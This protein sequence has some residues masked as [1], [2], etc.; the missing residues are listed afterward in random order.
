MEVPVPV[1]SNAPDARS[2]SLAR[3]VAEALR[4]LDWSAGEAVHFSGGTLDVSAQRRF[5]RGPLGARVRL[6]VF[7]DAGEPR[8]LTIAETEAGDLALASY[9]LGDDDRAQRD[10]IGRA[11]APFVDSAALTALHASAYPHEQSL[12]EPCRVPAPPARTHHAS[13][14]A[15]LDTT[16]AFAAIDAIRADLLAFDLDV[17]VDDLSLLA[18]ADERA[19]HARHS[20]AFRAASCDLIH[21]VLVTDATM[22]EASVR[23]VRTTLAGQAP[24]WIDVVQSE[25]FDEY[26]ARITSH[27]DAQFRRRNFNRA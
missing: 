11:L 3:P 18:G 9:A 16:T 6:A 1:T 26:A 4:G 10:A 25:A 24:R 17:V 27:Y 23:L 19:E 22:T 20:L 14:L 5:E 2:L 7:C 15:G 12:V 8:E 21:V 13:A